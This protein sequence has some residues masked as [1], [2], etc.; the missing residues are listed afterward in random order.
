MMSEDKG[1]EKLIRPH[2]QNFVGYSPSTSPE[3]L[4]GKVEVPIEKIIKL[5]ANEILMVRK[6]G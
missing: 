5:D 4:K 6:E 1:I 3:T 2:L